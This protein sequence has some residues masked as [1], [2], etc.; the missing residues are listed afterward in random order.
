M[1]LLTCNKKIKFN[2][3]VYV[4]I[5]PNN[6]HYLENNLLDKLWYSNNDIIYFKNSAIREIKELINKHSNMSFKDARYLLYENTKIMYN[7]TFFV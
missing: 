6:Q 5:I 7:P 4:Y 2:N 3:Y 1:F